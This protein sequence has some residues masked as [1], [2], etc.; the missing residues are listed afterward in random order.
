MELNFSRISNQSFKF[1]WDDPMHST[2]VEVSIPDLSKLEH[3]VWG[4][5][6]P[7]YTFQLNEFEGISIKYNEN[8]FDSIQKQL[9]VDSPML[10][11]E[12]EVYPYFLIVED[13]K[14]HLN[15][16]IYIN[17]DYELGK[18]QVIRSSDYI[19]LFESGEENCLQKVV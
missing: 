17:T 3:S 18:V 4:D 6:G 14:R 1:K 8:L 15:F 19:K 5:W 16:H 9:R 11:A 13:S 10:A 2:V 7:M 12:R